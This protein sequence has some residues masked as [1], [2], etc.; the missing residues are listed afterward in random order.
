MIATTKQ[1]YQNQV[2]EK[3]LKELDIP[4]SLYDQAVARYESISKW[5]ERSDS[6]VRHLQPDIF[7]QGSFRLGTVIKPLG[8]REEYDLDVVCNLQSSWQDQSQWDL[9]KL[10]GV[11]FLTYSEAQ[12]FSKSPVDK[13]RCWTQQYQD[14]VGF[15][16]DLL[17][18]IPD[19][20]MAIFNRVSKGVET[21]YAEH[22]IRITDKESPSYYR[23][24]PGWPGS[25]P[26]GY[27]L[28]FENRMD[29]NGRFTEERR[30]ILNRNFS[31]YNRTEDVPAYRAKTPLQRCIQLLKR[32]R[33]SLYTHHPERDPDRKPISVI[34]STLSARAYS[35]EPDVAT[36]LISILSKMEDLVDKPPRR[37]V[38]NP[39]DPEEDFAD[40]WSKEPDLEENF[41]WWLRHAKGDFS[42]LLQPSNKEHLDAMIRNRMSV[43]LPK[44][45]LASLVK[46]TTGTLSTA[47]IPLTRISS[48]P[49]PW[50]V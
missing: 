47:S 14:R 7:P 27:A 2:L 46:E 13:R 15:H 30:R 5:L 1:N 42:E 3:I 40:R 37:R 45:D 6:S 38:P 4:P 35:G 23:V 10:I 9:K 33:D 31:I 25:N 50:G 39:V 49:K 48:P 26:R 18:C 44:N 43:G 21:G 24:V 29:M 16:L 28:W 19:E 22:A 8:E 34:I 11:E 36:A 41:F 12:N 20:R 17:P 32:H